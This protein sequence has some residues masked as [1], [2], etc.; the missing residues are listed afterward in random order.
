MDIGAKVYN[1]RA[2]RG[3]FNVSL[4]CITVVH[5]SGARRVAACFAA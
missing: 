4:S 5:R 1:M 2:A 3:L